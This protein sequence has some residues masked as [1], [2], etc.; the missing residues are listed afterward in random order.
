[1]SYVNDVSLAEDILQDVFM[2]L[3]NKRNDFKKIRNIEAWMM[4][5]TRNHIYDTLKSNKHMWEDSS[6]IKDESIW[7]ARQKA[8]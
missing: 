8:F 4:T 3:W 5:I 2:K 1:M 7:T 6:L